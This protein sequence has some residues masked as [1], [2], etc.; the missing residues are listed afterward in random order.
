[1]N[2]KTESIRVKQLYGIFLAATLLLG[3]C[4]QE[5]GTNEFPQENIPISFSGNVPV[6]RSVKEY[7]TTSDLETIGVFAYFTH[8][9]FNE[10]TATPNFMY[11]Q[12]VGK[13]TDG[14]WSYSPVKF[15]PDNSTTDKISFFAYA[16]YINETASSNFFV[17]DKESSNGFPMLSYTVPTAENK[18]IDFLAATPVMNQNNGNVSF[19]LRH[20]LTKINVY[21]KS[22]DDTEGKSVTFF[23]ITGIKSG[24]LTYYTPTTDS[25]KG[26]LW[27][28][29][30]PDK[31]E[32]FTADITNFPVPNTIAE[33]KKLLA[34]F[35]LL[36][37]GKGSQF[38]ITY[39]YAAKDGN[40]NAI[41]QAIR[42]ENQSLPSTD[43]WNPGASV[44]YTIGISRKTISVMSE[45]D[46]ASWEGG[47]DSETVNGTEEKQIT[48]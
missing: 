48:N 17:Q 13:Q 33:E 38:S 12:L 8:G 18:Q 1:M 35:F 2:R 32:T 39:Q 20:T 10:D 37:A 25:D 43:T 7:T 22:N 5:E 21:V 29:P 47:T 36:P 19:K 14:T 46:I 27:A 11:N 15:W 45:N 31:K 41:T 16:P 42:I 9:N 24:I 30:S 4:T 3:A 44:S 26:W 34:T 40:N 28:F 6:M 23:S